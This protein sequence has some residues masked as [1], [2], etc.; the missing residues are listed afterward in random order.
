MATFGA[1]QVEPLKKGAKRL[2]LLGSGWI[3]GDR[4]NGLVITYL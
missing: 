2:D 3:N 1:P 4:I